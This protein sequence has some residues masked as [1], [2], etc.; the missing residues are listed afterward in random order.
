MKETENMQSERHRETAESDSFPA[1]V[2][3]P[4]ARRQI[5]ENFLFQLDLKPSL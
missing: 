2:N 5:Q 4:D 1:G 3:F